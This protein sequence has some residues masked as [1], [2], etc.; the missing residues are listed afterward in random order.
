MRWIRT[1]TTAFALLPAVILVL[2]QNS[3]EPS[4][5]L[6]H[7]RNLGK[8]F[9]ENPMTP[10]EAV[11]WFQKALELAP[12]S[13]REHL[14]YALALLEFGQIEEGIAELE[15][16]Q[17]QEP[18]IPHT[19]FNLGI[20]YKRRGQYQ[21]AQEQ[22]ERMVELVP[23]EPVSHYNLGILFRL[24]GEPDRALRHFEIAA[25]S[26]PYLAGPHYQLYGM[27]R[28]LGRS[29]EAAQAL[30]TFR[31]LRLSQTNTAIAEDL[32]WSVYAEIYG[33]LD[34]IELAD[35]S[36]APWELEFKDVLLPEKLE[37]SN[38]R[39]VVL[40]ADG[41]GI[42]DLLGWTDRQIRFYRRGSA[43]IQ[44]PELD[45]L[46]EV[47][48][49]APGDFNNDGLADLC[50]LT[51]SGP[52]FF[53]NQQGVFRKHSS[54]LLPERYSKPVWLDFD[55]DNDLDLFLFGQQSMLLRNNGRSGF[56]DYSDRFPF[57]PG[58][59]LDA[60][61]Y[62]LVRDAEVMDLAVAYKDSPIVIYRDRLGG[63]YEAHSLSDPLPG[64]K[65]IEAFDLNNDGWTDLAGLSDSEVFVLVNRE[66]TLE[67]I[68]VGTT[69][70]ESLVLADLANRG[71]VDL[72]VG[73]SAYQNQGRGRFS[74]VQELAPLGPITSVAGADFNGDGRADLAL[75]TLQG[76][77]HL[78]ENEAES[79]N[80]W[81]QLS[82][83]G[84]RNL[85]MAPG[86]KVEVRAGS[87][88]QKRIYHGVPLAFGMGTYQEIDV[89]RITWPNGLI[90]NEM[91]QPTGQA[92][93][94][95]EKERLSGSCPTVFTWNGQEFEFIGDMLGAAP[96]G[97]RISDDE[98]LETDHDEY[99]R[100]AGDSLAKVDGHYE[101]RITEELREVAYLDQLRLLAVDHPASMDIFSNDKFKSPPFPEFRLFGVEE[102]IYPLRAQDHRGGDVL[103]R[104]VKLDHRYPDDFSRDYTGV[105]EMHALE[106]DFGSG[107]VPEGRAVLV[108]NGWVDWPDSSSFVRMAQEG[109]GGLILPYLQVKDAQGSWQTVVEDMGFPAGKPKTIIVDLTNK[110]LSSAREVRIVT[111][112]CLYWDEI[113]IAANPAEPAVQLKEV[114]LDNAQLRFH[115]FSAAV[116]HPERK[117]PERFGYSQ[118]SAVS[119]WNP[120]SGFYTRYGDVREL[121]EAADD[122][123]VIMGSGDEIRLLFAVDDLPPLAKGF[124][125]DFLLYANGW[126]KDGDPNTAFAR[127]VGPLP[128]HDMSGYPYGDAERYPESQE[129]LRYLKEYNTRP[130]LR[131][132]QP[133]R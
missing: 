9:Y 107:A 78:L 19:W 129:N 95:E 131:L 42:S 30:E 91:Q 79:R 7:Y 38:P 50:V 53:A 102:R 48:F 130:A 3:P 49:V 8:A 124:K 24:G 73:S 86:A 45:E 97:F 127:T 33:V 103:G 110:F 120:T 5:A 37:G 35:M 122:R 68:S 31:Q 93:N 47:T 17:R 75:V 92:F 44:Q 51:E 116:I 85:S 43:P 70:D 13:P 106:L 74:P 39:L 117:Q 119:M 115:G 26:D 104:I 56:T 46:R 32:E 22:F 16:V 132:I 123:F 121:I 82:L 105:A 114:P 6:W 62:D 10:R 126:V 52:I 61:L 59:A 109:E 99:I 57:Q 23:E 80:R 11:E 54:F 65:S 83:T 108:L 2:G 67:K 14:N 81:L 113:F 133:L 63:H 125:R 64:I 84:V 1:L 128:F 27:Y 25:R 55:H 100:I 20:A 71:V 21:L 66:G 18:E 12:D 101:I 118:W 88:Y 34:P 98:Y 87:L 77:I 89:V 96:L 69:Q 28:L 41:D 40:E 111:N 60:T 76:K 112:L 4:E 90:Q 94:Y 58:E 15:S 72:V 36:T 29:D